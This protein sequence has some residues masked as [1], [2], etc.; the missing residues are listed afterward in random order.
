MPRIHRTISVR[1]NMP[2]PLRE[3]APLELPNSLQERA[4]QRFPNDIRRLFLFRLN[5]KALVFHSQ[6]WRILLTKKLVATLRQH[7]RIYHAGSFE[8]YI[9]FQHT[10]IEYALHP[11]KYYSYIY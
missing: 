2:N 1:S 5:S 6:T 3:W 10:G 7:H 9:R 4:S 8:R 11:R